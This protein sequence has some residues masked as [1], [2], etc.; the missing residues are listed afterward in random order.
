MSDHL[1]LMSDLLPEAMKSMESHSIGI[2]PDEA[3]ES[4]S[5]IRGSGFGE[6]QTED[7]RRE[8][9]RIE[10]DTTDPSSEDLS[11]ATPR[12]GDHEDRTIDRIDRLLLR[13]IESRVGIEKWSH[14]RGNYDS[15]ISMRTRNQVEKIFFHTIFLR[16]S[17]FIFDKIES[18]TI[19]N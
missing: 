9:I 16:K 7:I 14:I 17:N 13:G 10:E 1:C 12:S 15:S 11:L 2:C 6:G 19:N 18:M 4:R 3:S 5:H 8:D